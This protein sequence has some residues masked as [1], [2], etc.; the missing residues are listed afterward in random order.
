[1]S[2]EKKVLAFDAG[3]GS[4]R[5][6]K[7]GFDGSR[8]SLQQISRFA[9]G[10]VSAG[11]NLYWDILGIWRDLK[12]GLRKAICEDREIASLGIDTW[13]NDFVLLDRKGCMLENPYTYRDSRT[14]G[15][16]EE[17]SRQVGGWDL[18]R[19]NGIQQNRMNTL[20][21]LYHLSQ[22]RPYI[23][24]ITDRFLFIADFLAF[25][26]TGELYNEYTMATISQ[27][28]NYSKAGWDHD[29]MD[30]LGIPA[31]IFCSIIKP[32]ETIGRISAR[33]CEE[34]GIMPLKLT[35][36]AAHD[37]GSAVAAVPS[38]E[39]HP[40]YI[41][42]GTWS[43]V[44]TEVDAPLISE[45]AYHFNCA[46]EGGANGKIRLLKNVMGLWI[47]QEIQRNLAV[48][49]KQYSFSELSSLAKEAAPFAAMIDPDDEMFY[50]PSDMIQAIKEYCIRTG[51]KAPHD[52]G[53]IV[54]TVLESLAFKYRFVIE[55]LERITG[56]T[57]DRIHIVGGGSGNTLLNTFTANCCGRPVCAGP[58]EATALGN[59]IVQLISLGEI[60]DFTQARSIV[61]DSFQPEEFIPYDTQQWDE[62]YQRFL[63]MIK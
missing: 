51:Q 10:P 17:V 25:C 7:I 33:V 5:I 8:F 29:L 44:G 3:G 58:Q 39:D 56:H 63:E 15:L 46:N 27:L 14:V 50:E 28:Y 42:S 59:G 55:G 32:G 1:M 49:G 43:I 35:A 19:R 36:V 38:E 22:Q 16:V 34:A 47:I 40:L 2:L 52:T 62:A 21:Q 4:T 26:L 37:T 9:N 24:E 45:E 18:Y 53:S 48:G 20:Y 41:S 30:L 13:G 12:D 23:L 60:S 61:R 57:Y 6:T 54:R 31:G 11:G